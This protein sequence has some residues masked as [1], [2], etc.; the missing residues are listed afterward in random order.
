MAR[1][2]VSDNDAAVLTVGGSSFRLAV[3]THPELPPGVA[4]VAHGLPD[5]PVIE[6]PAWAEVKKAAP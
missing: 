1:L 3:R 4:A 6:F 5:A 2:H